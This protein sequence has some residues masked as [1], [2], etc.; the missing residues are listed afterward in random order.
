MRSANYS[1]QSGKDED[2]AEAFLTTTGHPPACMSCTP[3]THPS[4]IAGE[5]RLLTSSNTFVAVLL[6][7]FLIIPPRMIG[8]LPVDDRLVDVGG[9]RLHLKCAGAGGPTV[10]LEAGLG[11]SSDG[12]I[13]V[14]PEVAKFTR[15]CAYDRAGEGK[16]DP[17][18]RRL[19]HVGTRTYIELRD[20]EDVVRDLH[21]LLSNA[22]EN[23]P[24]VI[25]GHSLGGL[26]SILYAGTYPKSVA[27][28]VLEDSSHPDQVTQKVQI[29]GAEAT[30]TDHDS[31]IQNEEGADVDAI[32]AEVRAAHWHT[33]I[34]LYVLCRGRTTTPSTG[35]SQAL[36]DQLYQAHL[37]LQQDFTRRSTDSKFLV[38]EKS[39]HF[40]HRDQPELVVQAIHDVVESARTQTTLRSKKN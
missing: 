37:L 26:Y 7:T 4:A 8:Q 23:G 31:L 5:I 39:G 15:V 29:L 2:S 13:K 32:Y 18:P 9:Y 22:N 25:V 30:K 1:D 28:M 19:T 3:L 33:N 17:A 10:V 38:A 12:G 27:G 16:S 34:P 14:M 24:Y 6:A 20:G 35:R 40:I 36:T 21:A 11:G